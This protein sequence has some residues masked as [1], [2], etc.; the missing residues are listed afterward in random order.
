MRA[1][2]FQTATSKTVSNPFTCVEH[3]AL[4]S[5]GAPSGGVCGARLDDGV[6]TT[7]TACA[8]ALA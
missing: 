5:S 7:R 4:D 8:D 2:T 6:A 1:I 3:C